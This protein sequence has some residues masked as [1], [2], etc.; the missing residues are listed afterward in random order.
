MKSYSSREI[1]TILEANEWYVV[2]VRGDHWK[3]K[4]D[5]NPNTIVLTHPVKDVSIGVIR[6]IMKKSGLKF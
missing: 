2:S 4:H 1:K 6:D 5:N 3:F